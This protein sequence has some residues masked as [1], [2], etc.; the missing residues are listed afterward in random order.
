MMPPKLF[1]NTVQKFSFK[2]YST[3]FSQYR[4]SIN[5][6]FSHS[7]LLCYTCLYYHKN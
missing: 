3:N 5:F 2:K 7:I 4:E 6:I 1:V